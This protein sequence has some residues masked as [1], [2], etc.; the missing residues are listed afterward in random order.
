MLC[1]VLGLEEIISNSSKQS[2][3]M[4]PLGK[5]HSCYFMSSHIYQCFCSF[6]SPIIIF[7]L[8]CAPVSLTFLRV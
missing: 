8:S 3:C 2:L 1:A 6:I 4:T 5:E 7:N